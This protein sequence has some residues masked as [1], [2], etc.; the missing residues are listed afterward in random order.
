MKSFVAKFKHR[1]FSSD[2]V[3][4]PAE[5]VVPYV[6]SIAGI[7]FALGV[8]TTFTGLSQ[9]KNNKNT[10]PFD[11]NN[12]ES[13][14]ETQTVESILKRNLFNVTGAIPDAEDNG[15]IVC[16]P[17]PIKSEL[18]YKIAGIIFGGTSESSIVQFENSGS[19]DN[20][21]S[22]SF[23]IGNMLPMGGRLTGI[24][25]NRIL[26]TNKNCPEYIDLVYP[27]PPKS[28]ESRVSQSNTG[29]SFKENGFERNGNVSTASKQWVN[30]I[31]TNNFAKTLEDA[32]AS[33]YL[34]G[35]QVKGFI[36]TNITP[37]S[38]YAKLGLQNGDIVNSINNI[39]LNDAARAIQT[40]NSMRNEN[41]IVLQILRSG[42]QT[43]LK[44]N[45]Q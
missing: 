37:N 16:S 2:L 14:T 28:R 40:L 4:P 9:S 31:L 27:T 39:Q 5:K 24:Q 44:A 6:Y 18:Q 43:E 3:I 21:K 29:S 45:I 23:V 22:N 17:N 26:I 25:K 30:N 8:V 19:T 35:G 1:I 42:K 11:I 20:K 10:Q 32:K 38:V 41:T 34:V 12:T 36:L 33:P 13:L 15:K 7:S